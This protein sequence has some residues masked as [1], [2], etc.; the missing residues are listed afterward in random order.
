MGDGG[1]PGHGEGDGD[2]EQVAGCKGGG[3]RLQVEEVG[4]EGGR[5]AC[6]DRPRAARRRG[7]P[8]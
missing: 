2:D 4:L 6:Q 8:A 5:V 7:R 3:L 1:G